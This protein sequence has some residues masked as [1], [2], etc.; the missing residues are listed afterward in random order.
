VNVGTV[1]KS[2]AA[3]ASRM[4]FQKR[5]PSLR[6]IG[7]PWRFPHPAQDGRFRKVEAKH[8]QFAMNARRTPG[9]VL[10][11]LGAL[12]G[13]RLELTKPAS[14]YQINMPFFLTHASS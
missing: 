6:R 11:D 3:I 12:P 7:I 10:G 4:A 5:H 9:R 8:L 14:C 2:I 1:K 13:Q